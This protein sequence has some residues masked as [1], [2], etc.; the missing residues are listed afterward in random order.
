MPTSA[1]QGTAAPVVNIGDNCSA[2]EQYKMGKYHN[3]E[4]EEKALWWFK[5]AAENG[6]AAAQHKVAEIRKEQRW[7]EKDPTERE[8]LRQEIMHY[9]AAAFEQYHLPAIHALAESYRIG[10]NYCDEVDT[11]LAI[12]HHRLAVEYNYRG[13]QYA[14][15]LI[16]LERNGNQGD[17]DYALSMLLQAASQGLLLA[18]R[19]LA[20]IFTGGQPGVPQVKALAREWQR[21]AMLNPETEKQ[22]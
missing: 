18:Q 9:N 19:K 17:I 13:S 3:Y 4:D 21:L 5:K 10:D 11:S 14:L 8:A 2:E 6:H 16:F 22:V 20:R 7:F 1:T 12:E 15:G